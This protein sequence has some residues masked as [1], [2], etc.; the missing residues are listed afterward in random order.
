[1]ERSRA[2]AGVGTTHLQ[3]PESKLCRCRGYVLDNHGIVTDVMY[4]A[5]VSCNALMVPGH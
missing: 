1:M 5:N 2:F 3:M 4:G